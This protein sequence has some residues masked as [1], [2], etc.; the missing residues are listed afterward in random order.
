M[1]A[2]HRVL[3][4]CTIEFMTLG[5]DTL[6]LPTLSEAQVCA[7]ASDEIAQARRLASAA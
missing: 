1:L 2:K 4:P 3:L 6:A 5:G 7:V